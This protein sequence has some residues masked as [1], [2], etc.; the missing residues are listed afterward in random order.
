[1]PSPWAAI[2]GFMRELRTLRDD[3]RALDAAPDSAVVAEVES[4]NALA[5]QAVDETIS[6]PENDVLLTGAVKAIAAARERIK[7]LKVIPTRMA[8]TIGID[9]PGGLA[10]RPWKRLATARKHV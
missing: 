8:A 2:D 6:E 3:A 9:L 7:A 10:R 5:A 4:L 1:M